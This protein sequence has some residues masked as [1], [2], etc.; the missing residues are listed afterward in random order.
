[1]LRLE[2][3]VAAHRGLFAVVFRFG[4]SEALGHEGAGMVAHGGKPL[5][6][7]L[8]PICRIQPEAG[9]KGR[10]RQAREGLVD[11]HTRASRTTFHASSSRESDHAALAGE[12]EGKRMA[13]PK[14]GS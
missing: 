7:H 11:G 2:N 13:G 1:M 4:G 5:F 14:R 3:G 12:V 8:S 9:T 6:L 10:A